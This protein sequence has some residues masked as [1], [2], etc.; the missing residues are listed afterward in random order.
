VRKLLALSLVLLALAPV[1]Q[2]DTVVRMTIV[3]NQYV[4]DGE[5]GG[6][7]Q[8]YGGTADI[9]LFDEIAPD[10]VDNFLT[11]VN[12]GAYDW[13][14]FHRN[15][16]YGQN[17][18]HPEGTP[19]VLQGGGF[20]V[21]ETGEIIAIPT[22][23]P[24]ANEYGIPNTRGTVAMAK[25][26]DDPDSA[27]SQFFFNLS[28]NSA[29]LGPP[30]NGGFSVFGHVLGD[31]MD[32]IDFYASQPTYDL[33]GQGQTAPYASLSETP[34]V[35]YQVG[36]WQYYLE[37]FYDIEVLTDLDGDVN[38]DGVVDSTDAEAFRG[39]Y[40][41][42]DATWLE[43]DFNGNGVVDFDDAWRLL[44]NYDDTTAPGVSVEYLTETP[45]PE[46]ATMAV[47]M[48]GGLLTLARRRR[49]R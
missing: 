6:D 20:T 13:S 36:P 10:T 4:D 40:G 34:L 7:W 29:T 19:F 12:E 18:Y 21:G 33:R 2:A 44:G 48:V 47:L 43:G 35:N 23:D 46:P 14:F 15:A 30:N 24:V 27:T 38:L 49:V 37:T 39:H 31:G 8:L 17:G 25:L 9:R 42:L 28:D 32:L 5:G 41:S 1:L 3:Y 26:G 45:V 22:H 11:Y 16:K